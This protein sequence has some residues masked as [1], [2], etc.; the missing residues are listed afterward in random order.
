[1]A[2]PEFLSLTYLGGSIVSWGVG[3]VCD[4]GFLTSRAEMQRRLE[5]GPDPNHDIEAAVLT[6]HYKALAFIVEDTFAQAE[7]K[8]VADNSAR[9][10]H[11]RSKQG[12]SRIFEA[13]DKRDFKGLVPSMADDWQTVIPANFEATNG[14]DAVHKAVPP[15]YTEA[16]KT[17]L[18]SLAGWSKPEQEALTE[19]IADPEYGWVPLF[20]ACLREQIKTDDP[21]RHIYMAQTQE[22]QLAFLQEI[23]ARLNTQLAPGKVLLDA[24]GQVEVFLRDF[25]AE[26]REQHTKTHK[27][28]EEIKSLI[29]SIIGDDHHR[30]EVGL[31]YPSFLAERLIE[32]DLP[33][34]AWESEITTALTR[35]VAGK[36]QLEEH[37]QLPH[38]L[39]EKRTEALAL[40]EEAKLDQGEA[41]LQELIETIT[42]ERLEIAAR[43][44]AHILIDQIPF[45]IA[46]LDYHR[47]LYLYE[48]AA[49]AVL[50]TDKHQAIEWL[51]IGADLG[52]ERGLLFGGGL[53]GRSKSLYKSTLTHIISDNGSPLSGY[54]ENWAMTQNNLG[55]VYQVLG[56][57]GED[58]ALEQAVTAYKAALTVRTQDAAPM[59][60]AMTTENLGYVLWMQ[61]QTKE[62]ETCFRGALAAFRQ[63]GASWYIDKLETEMRSRGLTP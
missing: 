60:W 53:L 3:K 55:A 11:L 46:K 8:R 6:A 10:T 22:H 62:A 61:G 26:N 32:L 12:F 33:E 25:R 44:H 30:T 31:Y 37:T 45:V 29:N 38:Y 2:I 35:Y 36:A 23:S 28:I 48:E 16:A 18:L 14:L 63:Q 7:D 42:L 49:N 21:F 56:E 43:D 4:T 59:N 50:V 40:Y 27:G 9:L 24:M 52:Y 15:D 1:M 19:R 39:E 13:I 51:M 5:E 47:A 20:S 41:V 17:D 34:D 57:R 58:G 54:E